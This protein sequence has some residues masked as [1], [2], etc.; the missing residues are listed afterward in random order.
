VDPA[1]VAGGIIVV[2]ARVISPEHFRII[3]EY[4]RGDM[5]FGDLANFTAYRN[6]T[7]GLDTYWSYRYELRDETL[8]GFRLGLRFGGQLDFVWSRLWGTSAYQVWLD[9][10]EQVHDPE[11]NP[12]VLLPEVD[13]RLDMLTLAWRMD[14]MRVA[15]IV[16]S[17]SMGYGWILTSQKGPFQAPFRLPVDNSDSDDVFSLGVGL[18]GNWRILQVGTELSGLTWRWE[19]TDPRVP[20][21]QVYSWMWSLRAGLVF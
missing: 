5:H 6:T 3:L 20:S 8:E 9:D 7:S 19:S 17:L 18:E 12:R 21:S 2:G 1:Y 11:A 10:E 14:S 13:I 16:P 15:G 4:E